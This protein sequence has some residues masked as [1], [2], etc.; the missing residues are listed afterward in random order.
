MRGETR[1]ERV[2]LQVAGIL[3]KVLGRTITHTKLTELELATHLQEG[4]MPAEDAEML[5]QMD[6]MIK[7]GGEDRMN[8]V[9]EEATGSKPCTFYVRA[10]QNKGN[11]T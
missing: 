6:T 5:A 4:G 7:G 8:N 11:F 9:V 10:L 1:T 3:T 2:K